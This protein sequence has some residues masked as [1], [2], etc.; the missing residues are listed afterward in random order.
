M[1]DT[2]YAWCF[3]HGRMHTFRPSAEYPNGAWCT[4]HW[5]HLGPA[6]VSE[7]TAEKV[8]QDHFGHAR[9]M[10]ELHQEAQVAVMEQIREREAAA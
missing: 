8:K 1:S 6:A 7:E 5:V 10:H 4:A 2:T 3:S 9:F